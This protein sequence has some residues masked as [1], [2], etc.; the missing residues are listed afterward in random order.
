MHIQGIIIVEEEEEVRNKRWYSMRRYR[1]RRSST[2]NASPD[3]K[4]K[5]NYP[6]PDMIREMLK[7]KGL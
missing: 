3:T 4:V 6:T 1:P 2:Y 5:N 7:K